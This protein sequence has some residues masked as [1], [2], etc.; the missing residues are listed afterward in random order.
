M[1]GLDCQRAGLSGIHR[2]H[3]RVEIG[4]TV[5]GRGERPPTTQGLRVPSSSGKR[6]G[7]PLRPVIDRPLAE[8][9]NKLGHLPLVVGRIPFV[10][11]VSPS[12][13]GS[14]D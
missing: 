6:R 13:P 1:K 8:L 14:E 4:L 2:P 12:S 5:D 10:F 3:A 7:K 11:E 9:L